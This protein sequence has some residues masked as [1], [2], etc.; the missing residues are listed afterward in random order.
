MGQDKGC[1]SCRE[2]VPSCSSSRGAVVKITEKTNLHLPFYLLGIPCLM[3]HPMNI[4]SNDAAEEC[5][6]LSV[7]NQAKS[8]VVGIPLLYKLDEMYKH[9]HLIGHELRE[10]TRVKNSL[11]KENFNDIPSWQDLH[12]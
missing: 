2:R 12:S 4:L 7:T 1:S 6:A 3:Q 11:C 5:L 10:T 9:I 8:L